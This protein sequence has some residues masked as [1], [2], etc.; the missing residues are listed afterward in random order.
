MSEVRGEKTPSGSDYVSDGRLRYILSDF[1]VFCHFFPLIIIPV[2]KE[3]YET[4]TVYQKI[5]LKKSH[6]AYHVFF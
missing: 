1:Y 5:D 4:A 3:L 2:L 6:S